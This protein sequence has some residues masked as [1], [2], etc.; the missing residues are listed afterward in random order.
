MGIPDEITLD[1]KGTGQG[2]LGKCS[3]KST[4]ENQLVA[5]AENEN[6]VLYS[7]SE[8]PI[9]L[10]VSGKVAC[11]GR[12]RWRLISQD[13]IYSYMFYLGPVVRALE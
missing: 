11:G 12:E 13:C 7:Q 4:D 6:S 9:Q 5:T 10:V 8:N 2:R 1:I 3:P